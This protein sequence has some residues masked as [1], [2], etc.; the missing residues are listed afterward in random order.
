MTD[1]RTAGPFTA[2]AAAILTL[3]MSGCFVAG[4][5]FGERPNRAIEGPISAHDI[6]TVR[7]LVAAGGTDGH[8]GPFEVHHA[9]LSLTPR[10]PRSVEIFRLILEQPT[11]SPAPLIGGPPPTPANMDLTIRDGSGD[12][13]GDSSP[14]ELAAKQW[15]A[16]GLRVLLDLGLDVKSVATSGALA[17]AAANGCEPCLTVLLDAGADVNGRDR[18]GDTALIMARRVGN[19]AMAELLLKRGARA[20]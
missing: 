5:L 15:S 18:N 4:V 3:I 19:T 12:Y 16:D 1:T 2:A 8:V 14:A 13:A 9:A 6:A 20:E 10:D 7:R 17:H 11:A